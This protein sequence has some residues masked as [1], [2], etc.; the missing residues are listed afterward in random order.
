MAAGRSTIHDVARRAGVSATTVS[1]TFTGKG[2]VAADTQQH[3]REVA[4]AMGYRPDAVARGLRKNRMGIL[5]LVMRPLD[6]LQ[7][8]LPDGVDYF[9]R[10]AGAAAIAAMEQ[11]YGL[12]LVSDPTADETPDAARAC[13]GFLITEPVVG[14]PLIDLL[15]LAHVPFLAVGRVPKR[16]EVVHALDTE[17]ELM[18]VE[19]LDHLAAAGAHNLA[20]V[21]GT[22]G[23]AWNIDAESA[24]RRWASD[25]G[26][27]PVVLLRPETDG[28]AAGRDAARE[29][30]DLTRR[31]DAVYCLTGRHAAGLLLGLQAGGLAVPDDVMIVCGSDSEHT[32]GSTPSITAVDLRP[33]LLARVAVTRL[34]N[35]LD[36][37]ARPLPTGSVRG[38]L[39]VRESTGAPHRAPR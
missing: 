28:E 4:L 3:V 36:A 21:R 6:T 5:G 18:T 7:P 8:Y 20:L 34:T 15:T 30:V 17:T 10:F 25:H 37:A 11:G 14:D 29:L 9:L 32:R 24:Y 33:D 27:K 39:V 1:H 26:Q 31:P 2:V 35:H 16:P 12:M 22:D 23:N 13:D 38:R 19:V